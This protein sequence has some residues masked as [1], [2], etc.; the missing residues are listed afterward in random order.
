MTT[1]LQDARKALLAVTSEVIDPK[2]RV[3]HYSLQCHYAVIG[4]YLDNSVP[5]NIEIENLKAEL[6][7]FK[8]FHEEM[9]RITE[10]AR[11]VAVRPMRAPFNLYKQQF[12]RALRNLCAD[13]TPD[14]KCVACRVRDHA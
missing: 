4:D 13:C 5:L 1:S 6:A 8:A 9:N 2:N 14:L 7:Q 10:A 11:A 12:G 3:Q